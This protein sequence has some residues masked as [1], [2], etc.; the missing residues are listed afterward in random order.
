MCFHVIMTITK[1]Q[2]K[3]NQ[4]FGKSRRICTL[5]WPLKM[6]ISVLLGYETWDGQRAWTANMPCPS[7]V[8]SRFELGRLLSRRAHHLFRKII[9]RK[10]LYVFF[11]YGYI[12]NLLL[13]KFIIFPKRSR[14]NR[15][16]T[17]NKISSPRRSSALTLFLGGMQICIT[18]YIL[19]DTVEAHTC[20]LLRLFYF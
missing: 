16:V 19:F 18:L 2:Y 8:I 6:P 13:S 1:N 5:I 4:I 15:Y 12:V 20:K 17:S 7:S 11:V 3:A 14:F 9:W 10:T